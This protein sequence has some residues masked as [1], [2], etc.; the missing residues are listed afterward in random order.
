MS[1]A[2]EQI[3][4]FDQLTTSIDPESLSK[5]AVLKVNGGLGTSMG[6]FKA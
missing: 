6:V 5:L 4:P 2:E 3:V 1:P